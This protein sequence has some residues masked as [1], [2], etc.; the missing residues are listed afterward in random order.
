MDNRDAY[1]N[2]FNNSGDSYFYEKYRECRNLVN[3]A[4]RRAKIDDYNRNINN[5]LQN[6]KAF[7]RNL[8]SYDIVA[9]K[10]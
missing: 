4:V 5:K 9:Y 10:K 1:K 2:I 6:I 7:H 3:H 8:K